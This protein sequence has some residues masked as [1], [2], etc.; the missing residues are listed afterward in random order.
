MWEPYPMRDGA[1]P[2][3]V[4]S[5]PRGGRSPTAR[6]GS[7]RGVRRATACGT[8]GTGA[9]GPEAGAGRCRRASEA[10]RPGG[11]PGPRVRVA[12]PASLVWTSAWAWPRG[13]TGKGNGRRGVGDPRRQRAG[14]ARVARAW[15]CAAGGWREVAGPEAVSSPTR[16][17]GKACGSSEAVGEE[18]SGEGRPGAPR[19]QAPAPNKGLQATAYSLRSAPASGST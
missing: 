17:R 4:G 6:T 13:L 9:P 16:N 19:C 18:A 7:A 12:S 14:R 8:T 1:P 10:L 2:S 11:V 5:L 3:R 15:R